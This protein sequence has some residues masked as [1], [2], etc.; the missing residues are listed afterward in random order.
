MN[1]IT[2]PPHYTQYDPEPIDVIEA[3][4]LP[5][6]E[7]T[8]LQ[9]IIRHRHKGGVEDLKK[10]RYY[11]ERLIDMYAVPA[12]TTGASGAVDVGDVR[13]VDRGIGVPA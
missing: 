12:P 13:T 10:A 11:I 4:Q 9:Y 7:A 6:H 2:R 3:W 5:F 8:I 1:P